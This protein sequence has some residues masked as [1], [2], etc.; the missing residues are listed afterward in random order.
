MNDQRMENAVE[1]QP[2]VM[3]D[4]G[5]YGQVRVPPEIAMNFVSDQG[6]KDQIRNEC[7]RLRDARRRET[8]VSRVGGLRPS[9]GVPPVSL[10]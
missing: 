5:Q 4:F 1:S 2:L 8:A 9:A 6:I 7:N 3:L 10:V